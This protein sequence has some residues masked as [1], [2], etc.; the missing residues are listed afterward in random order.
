MCS[1]QCHSY[2]LFSIFL[3]FSPLYLEAWV[4]SATTGSVNIAF[5]ECGVEPVH[6]PGMAAQL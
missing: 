5:W 4:R 6:G 1:V 2:F 3:S